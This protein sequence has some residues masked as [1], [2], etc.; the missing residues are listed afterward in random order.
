[1]TAPAAQP[2]VAPPVF[3]N[4]K[5]DQVWPLEAAWGPSAE[6]TAALAQWGA[7]MDAL[8]PREPLGRG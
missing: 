5:F 8:F 3:Y 6:F 1:V 7:R 4:P 2:A